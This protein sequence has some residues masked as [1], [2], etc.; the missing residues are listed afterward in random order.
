M[1]FCGRDTSF[2]CCLPARWGTFLTTIVEIIVCVGM[3]IVPNMMLLQSALAFDIHCDEYTLT[4][5]QVSQLTEDFRQQLRSRISTSTIEQVHTAYYV[6]LAF[7]ALGALVG[8]IGLACRSPWMVK[9]YAVFDGLSI[10]A[11][12]AL[13]CVYVYP[14]ISAVAAST[15]YIYYQDLPEITGHPSEDLGISIKNVSWIAVTGFLVILSII[16]IWF[17]SVAADAA[18]EIRQDNKYMVVDYNQ[19]Q[20]QQPL[21]VGGQANGSSRVVVV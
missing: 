15:N 2:L 19:Q 20:Q 7:I 12:I 4:H 8:L 1:G 9:T 5:T 10:I 3:A 11:I 21:L 14:N 16:R 18:R 6:M 13:A 17:V